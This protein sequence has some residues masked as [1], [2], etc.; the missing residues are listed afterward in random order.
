MRSTGIERRRLLRA[1]AGFSIGGL[2]I[3]GLGLGLG[4]AAPGMGAFNGSRAAERRGQRATPAVYVAAR[5]E[6]EGRHVAAVFDLDAGD[7]ALV[8]L[9]GRGHDV[10]VCRRTGTFVVFA[11]RPGRFAIAV[12][13][14]REPAIFTTPDDRHFNGHGVFSPAGDLLYATE[15]DFIGQR[16]VLGLYRC[17]GRHDR[18]WRRIG[19]LPTFGI[20][21]HE[22]G[23]LPDGDTL[24][25]ANG[26]ILTDP[27]VGD[28]RSAIGRGVQADL[29]LIDRRRGDRLGQW[30]LPPELA[31]LSIRHL[32]LDRRGSVW[33]GCQWEGVAGA[34]PPLLGRLS[35][36]GALEMVETSAM[37]GNLANYVGSV[38]ADRTGTLIAA[39]SPRA[40]AVAIL[41]A[42][43]A[44]TLA[45]VP[46]ADGCG[47]AGQQEG[48]GF[49]ATSGGGKVEA[50][51]F[52]SD[53]VGEEPLRASAGR[54]DN[55]LR[56]LA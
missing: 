42:A 54:W 49:I 31:D 13:P 2:G 18:A 3:G 8:P 34:T 47:L 46:L 24:A 5:Q 17:P 36:Q 26:G 51:S 15:N 40:G 9:P 45:V 53:G 30:R 41:D 39:S 23:L 10:A 27:G 25:I 37:A 22:L 14:G 52:T 44:R 38:V 20:G 32:A 56:R 12:Q 16:G 50:L 35:P 7:G 48:R 29:V 21:P 28:G 33:F 11:R 19:E 43:S 6:A 4:F 1:A 55:H